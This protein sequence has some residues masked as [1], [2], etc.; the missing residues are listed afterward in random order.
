MV[1]CNN[2][3][4]QNTE[5]T[6]FCNDCGSK[7]TKSII[8][9]VKAPLWERFLAMLI[10]LFFE[11]VLSIPAIIFFVF[12]L[13]KHLRYHNNLEATPWYFIAFMFYIIPLTYSLIKDGQG[14]GQSWGKKTMGLMVVH[15]DFNLPCT[16]SR[17]FFRN[18]V[19]RI[20]SLIPIVGWLIEPILVLASSSGRKLGDRAAETMVIV[21]STYQE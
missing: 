9:Y 13:F 11:L 6:K 4:T 19:T 14:H 5:T 8:I 10:D 1:Y 17:S 15:L 7:I 3:G 16:K 18:L 2:C 20:I 12:G 21:A